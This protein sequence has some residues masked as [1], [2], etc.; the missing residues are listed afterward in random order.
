MD[1]QNVATITVLNLGIAISGTDVRD[2]TQVNNCK[3]SLAAGI[4]CQV[5][6]RF[7]PTASG[8]VNDGGSPQRVTL[9]G[10]GVCWQVYTIPR[11]MRRAP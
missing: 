10:T 6:V 11:L 2:F 1:L 4:S 5:V 3:I 8:T 7:R 9:N